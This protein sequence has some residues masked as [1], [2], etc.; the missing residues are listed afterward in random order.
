MFERGERTILGTRRY[1]KRLTISAIVLE[2]SAIKSEGMHL[3]SRAR[4]GRSCHTTSTAWACNQVQVRASFAQSGGVRV[5]RMAVW[6]SGIPRHLC[7][8]LVCIY[9]VPGYKMV[10]SRMDKY[11]KKQLQ[12]EAC[13]RK[14]IQQSAMIEYTRSYDSARRS[15]WGVSRRVL[16]LEKLEG[17]AIGGCGKGILTLNSKTYLVSRVASKDKHEQIL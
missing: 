5:V 9:K 17:V 10:F 8:T 2:V 6:I 11:R 1:W 15:H 7:A 13:G 4:V 12:V 3:T 14:R 16:C